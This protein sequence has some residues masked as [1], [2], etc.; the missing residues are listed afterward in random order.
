MHTN[1]SRNPPCPSLTAIQLFQVITPTHPSA[2]TEMIFYLVN[3]SFSWWPG[4]PVWHSRDLVHWQQ[5]GHVM[6]NPAWYDLSGLGV[7]RGLYA[8]TIR[9]HQGTFYVICTIVGNPKII[10]FVILSARVRIHNKDGHSRYGSQRTSISTLIY[11]LM[12]M[13]PSI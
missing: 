8:P 7:N 5:L 3:S 12:M 10:H 9:Y 4:L 6:E 13:V 2:E 1:D 11:S